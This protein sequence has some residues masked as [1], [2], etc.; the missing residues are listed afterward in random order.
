MPSGTNKLFYYILIDP[1]KPNRCKLGITRNPK[2]RLK[3]YR[4]ANPQ[5]SFLKVYELD[6][7]KHEK[8]ILDLLKDC[9]RVDREYI[10]ADPRLVKNIIEGYFLD[11]S[12]Y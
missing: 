3:S 11:K 4:T 8:K 9:F 5:C 7:K 1:D 6:D 10:H 12:D 2:Q